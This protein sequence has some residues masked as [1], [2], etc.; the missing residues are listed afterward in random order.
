M[1]VKC[2]L[3]W[4]LRHWC[5]YVT[6]QTDCVCQGSGGVVFVKAAQL[7]RPTTVGFCLSR[8][9]TFDVGPMLRLFELEHFQK[10]V[11]KLTLRTKSTMKLEAYPILYFNPIWY[12]DHKPFSGHFVLKVVPTIHPQASLQ[13]QCTGSMLYALDLKAP[14]PPRAPYLPRVTS[15][16]FYDLPQKSLRGAIAHFRKVLSALAT[17]RS[18]PSCTVLGLQKAK[19]R[20]YLH[21]LGPKEPKVGIIC[22]FP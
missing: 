15:M 20:S 13:G 18:P 21:T 19:S 17:L 8:V 12:M 7:Q 11:R 3:T 14:K 4:H 22:K 16:A 1:Y 10:A 5:R 2:A 6:C 9:H